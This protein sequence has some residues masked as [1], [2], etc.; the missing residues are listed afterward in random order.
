MLQDLLPICFTI[1]STGVACRT[2]AKCGNKW[3][4]YFR[5]LLSLF[6]G[7]LLETCTQLVIR[8]HTNKKYAP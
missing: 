2:Q 5:Q 8:V 1:L 3:L 6:A 4:W 7:Y